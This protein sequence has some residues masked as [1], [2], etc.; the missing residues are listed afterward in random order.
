[1]TLE[2]G[3]KKVLEKRV[4]KRVKSKTRKGSGSLAGGYDRTYVNHC[5]AH[6]AYGL[7]DGTFSII[8]NAWAHSVKTA[9]PK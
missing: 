3:I 6:G 8:S 5:R 9:E 2:I 7:Y 1:L 4:K